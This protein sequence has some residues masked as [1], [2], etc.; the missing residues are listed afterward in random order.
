MNSENK[1]S[2]ET[3]QGVF[4]NDHELSMHDCVEI[5]KE[6]QDLKGQLISQCLFDFFKF[7]KKTTKN[8]TNF[9]PRI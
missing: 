9:C 2:C 4:S 7:S 1:S 6:P 3:C 5:K 8:F